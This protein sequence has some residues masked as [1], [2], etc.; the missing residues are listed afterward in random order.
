M[1]MRVSLVA[2]TRNE[3]DNIES[4]LDSIF[5]QTRIPD[6]V[7][8]TDGGSTDDTA[9]AIASYSAAKH[10][11]QLEVLPGANRSRGRNRA[12]ELASFGIIAVTDAGCRLAEGW[13][14][15]IV[16]P[17]GE[18]A[19]VTA[20]AGFYAPE[21]ANAVEACIG[22]MT[23][24][25]LEAV[26][27]E[28]FLPSSR[29]VAFT[30]QAWRDAGGYPEEL[31]LNED[32]AFDLR[33]VASGHAFRFAPD[34]LVYWRP[35]K[36]PAAVYRQFRSYARG[37]AQASIYARTYAAIYVRYALV[38]LGLSLWAFSGR[39]AFGVAGILLSLPR[40]LR[41][42]SKVA[43]G[44][45]PTPYGRRARLWQALAWVVPVRLAIDWGD[46]VGWALGI[47][48]RRRRARC[49]ATKE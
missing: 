8:I 4:F 2:T 42:F 34:A 11:V 6:E 33:L 29:S 28:S 32:T 7:I 26:K 19:D 18:C 21:P 44:L 22:A 37:D 24:P 17:F 49:L 30:K 16:R 47:R 9:R 43:L 10:V 39:W 46:M 48:D 31:D 20:V 23:L 35:R 36:S 41:D 40:L 27:P 25:G 1:T 38:L 14:E 45:R 3:A 13:L 12:V 5:S 15:A